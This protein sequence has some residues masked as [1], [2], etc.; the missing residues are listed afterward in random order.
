MEIQHRQK[1]H[2][3]GQGMGIS[4]EKQLA[5]AGYLMLGS[6]Q[7]QERL[8]LSILD[9]GSLRYLKAIPYLIYQHDVDIEKIY[10]TTRHK[11]LLGQIITITRRIFTDA[12][13]AR[14]LPAIDEKS[15][16]DHE[17]FK[18]EFTMQ[19]SAAR[20]P[21]LIA[22]KQ[23]IYA[24]RDTLLSLSQLFTKKERQVIKSI[25]DDKPVC[26]T[27]YEY[28]SRKTKKKL[29]SILNLQELARTLANTSPKTDEDL[30]RLKA[31]L[32]QW[33]EKTHKVK[34]A[35]VARFF[36]LNQQLSVIYTTRASQEQILHAQEPLK[37]IHQSEMLRLLE[38]YKEG[39]FG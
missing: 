5:E 29:K 32:E 27:A 3:G 22:E 6:P 20:R 25:L 33:L 24:E 30:F 4:I 28:Y 9:D 31:L 11:K 16:L 37:N 34:D 7:E 35:S 8:I 13:I 1:P 10:A 12:G 26:K 2:Q 17:D 14:A 19:R 38:R 21:T 36:L 39:D 15:S 18:Q 23:K